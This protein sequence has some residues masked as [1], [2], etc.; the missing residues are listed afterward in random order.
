MSL[1]SNHITGALASYGCCMPSCMRYFDICFPFQS[2]DYLVYRISEQFQLQNKKNKTFRVES[3]FHS[4]FFPY[5][6]SPPLYLY[7]P[8]HVNMTLIVRDNVIRAHQLFNQMVIVVE[9]EVSFYASK[10]VLM[11][12]NLVLCT[13]LMKE[14]NK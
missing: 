13:E 14:I 5:L 9:R 8:C 6:L 11:K 3:W 10:L 2:S 4:S 12:M 7:R 1:F